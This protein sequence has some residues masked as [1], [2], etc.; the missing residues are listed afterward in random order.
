MILFRP[1]SQDSAMK[2]KIMTCGLNFE[3]VKNEEYDRKERRQGKKS[4][5]QFSSYQH[6]NKKFRGQ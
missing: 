5:G 1:M 6:Q 2:I 3:R 4:P